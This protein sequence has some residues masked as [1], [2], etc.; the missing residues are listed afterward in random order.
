MSHLV[1]GSSWSR[2]ATGH[3]SAEVWGLATAFGFDLL[4]QIISKDSGAPGVVGIC[5]CEGSGHWSISA[6]LPARLAV[7]LFACHMHRVLCLTLTLLTVTMAVD[8]ASSA[9]SQVPA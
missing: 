9:L 8:M 1:C 5:S 6:G 3:P 7:R 4:L 2:W